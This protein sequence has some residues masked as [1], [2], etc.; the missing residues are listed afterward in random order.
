MELPLVVGVDG[1]EAGMRA[2]DW[3]A[4]EATLHGIP[5]RLVYA[6]L[7]ARYEGAALAEG[8]DA[9]SERKL[10]HDIV[11]VAARR[12]HRRATDL[13][14]ATE[15]LP[16]E[17]VPA[18]L[19]AGRNA[20]ALVVGARGRSGIAELLLGSVGL[21]VAARAHC[22]VIVLRGSHDNQARTGIRQRIALGVGGEPHHAAAVRFAFREAEERRVPLEAVRAWRRPAHENA[23]HPLLAGAPARLHEERAAQTP[24]GG[25]AR[26]RHRP[27]PSVELHRRTVEGTARRVLLDASAHADLL[28]VG[29]RRR[30]GHFGLQLGRVAHTVL[31]HSACPVAVVPQPA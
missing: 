8:L 24:G 4:D 17:P 20:S 22:P 19:R 13:K 25:A 30:H 29:A 26:R 23:G 1:S 2:V 15:V 31:H 6:S 14:V 7:W 28:V 9:S 12:A 3:A 10:P 27:H 18:L 11:E 16:E 21:A 5:L